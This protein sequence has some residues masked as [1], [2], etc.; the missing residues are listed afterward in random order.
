MKKSNLVIF[1]VFA[2]IFVLVIPFWAISK[3]GGADASPEAIPE[4]DEGAQALFQT[5]CGPCHTLAKAGTDGVV[6]PNLDDI[7]V[8]DQPEAN[9]GRVLSAIDEGRAGRMPAD[10]LSGEAAKEV[11]DFVSRVAGQ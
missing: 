10:I 2:V 8:P 11:A 3:E 5:N 6:G 7:L 1:G 9:Y 4:E